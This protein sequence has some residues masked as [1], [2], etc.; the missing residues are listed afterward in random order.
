MEEGKGRRTHI[1]REKNSLNVLAN[2][3]KVKEK[4]LGKN[5]YQ[6]EEKTFSRGI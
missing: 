1:K 2:S 5:T 6:A 3:P 4:L